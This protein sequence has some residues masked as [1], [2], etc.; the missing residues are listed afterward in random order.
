MPFFYSP[1]AEQVVRAAITAAGGEVSHAALVQTLQSANKAKLQKALCPCRKTV[2]LLAR[3]RHSPKVS[4][5]CSIRCLPNLD[6]KSRIADISRSFINQTL[7]GKK[8]C[9]RTL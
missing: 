7:K 1:E 6:S 5:F 2:S 3:S 8:L 9:L 4:R